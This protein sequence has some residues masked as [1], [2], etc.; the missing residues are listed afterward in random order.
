MTIDHDKEQEASRLRGSLMEFIKYFTK[1][2]TNRDYI[3]SR[4]TGRESHQKII[5]RELVNFQRMQH[6]QENLLINVEPGSGK[7]LHICMWVAWCYTH[8][9]RCN[10]IYTSHS[11]EL[12]AE[13]TAFIKQIMSSQHYKYLFDVHI[14]KDTKSKEHFATTKGGHVAAFGA[15]GGIVGRNAGLPDQEGFTGALII[16]DAHKPDEAHSDTVRGKIIKNYEET[17]RQR[18]RGANVPII[19]IG[20]RVHEDDLAAYFIDGRDIK[21]WRLVILAAIDEAGNA[22]YPEV[23]TKEYLEELKIKSPFVFFSQFQQTPT[24]AGGS[25]FDPID[26]LELD[27]DPKFLV[28][29]VTAD[30]AETSRTHND[31][32]AISFLGLYEIEVFGRKSGKLGL[33]VIDQ[34]EEW[35][36][37][38]H[39][40]DRFLEFWSECSHHETPPFV[41]AI[42]KKSTGVTLLATLNK[43]QGIKIREVTRTKAD[44]S[45]AVRYI[46]MQPY[47]A[48]KYVTVTKG[49]KHVDNFKEH[50]A[51]ITLNNSHRHDDICHSAGSIIATT[52]GYVNVENIKIGDKVITPLGIGL[53][54]AC[55]STG[56]HPVIKKFGLESTPDH[57]IY[58][59]GKFIPLMSATDMTRL[60]LL[61]FMELFLWRQRQLFCLMV[62]NLDS[63]HR[64]HITNLVE[65]DIETN[66]FTVLYGN[67]IK[68]NQY[69]KALSFTIKTI[70]NLITVLKI[71][72]VFQVSNTAKYI[73]KENPLRKNV[74]KL[75]KR[76]GEILASRNLTQNIKKEDQKTLPNGLPL[77][78]LFN[79]LH[80][81]LNSMGL[82]ITQKHVPTNAS[83]KCRINGA[84]ID[85]LTD[86]YLN[87]Y[88]Y[89]AAINSQQKIYHQKN[90]T[91]QH[92]VAPAQEDMDI[93]EVFSLTVDIY[94]VYYCNNILLQNCDTIY[95]GINIGLIDKSLYGLVK[96]KETSAAN[97]VM[98]AIGQQ[99]KRQSMARANRNG[100]R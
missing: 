3:E 11:Q 84:E 8:D 48:S 62:K 13:Q 100:I 21:S 42:E 17:L 79:A 53:V 69:R 86:Q 58:Y 16:D 88:V 44:G 43:I 27:K 92:A 67:F 9:A 94:G 93:K 73:L 64:E 83:E 85:T 76:C 4:P 65:E 32:T 29:F 26:I 5:C 22:L 10:F 20:Q 52:R 82:G 99:M 90:I 75:W 72:S 77:K 15:G 30:T 78:N 59:D 36:D 95:D 96:S 18:P 49:R 91:P 6:P 34:I 89:S 68:N 87:H 63:R 60:S 25:A 66:F 31:P 74:K 98:S 40:E 80:A 35:I 81:V 38:A 37:A 55:G 41:A 19:F 51:K 97:E 1:Y 46:E 54:S 24:P 39:L 7:S 12:A 33:H 14:A 2:I 47:I 45:K 56:F 23:H 70:I 57:K 61:T 71:W 28:T 50:M